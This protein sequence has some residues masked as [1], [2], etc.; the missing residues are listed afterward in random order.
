[1][2][3]VLSAGAVALAMAAA[4]APGLG[5]A[6]ERPPHERPPDAKS[7]EAGLWYAAD[8]A[9]QG[10]RE[11][12]DLDTDSALNAYVRGVECKVAPEYCGEMRIYV[13]DRPIFNSMAAPNGY[14]EVWS[15][16]LLRARNE[17]ELAFILGHETTHY[18]M[19]HAVH[20]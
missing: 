3:P 18:G 6:Q 10:A 15:G 16:L 20:A 17:A 4:L 14:V 2:R 8:K 11:S 19:N 1:M 9:E 12:G 7:D 5:A 13:M